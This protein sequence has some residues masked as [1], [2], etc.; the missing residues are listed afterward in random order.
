[1]RRI[2]GAAVGLL[3]L[4]VLSGGC[5]RR[6]NEIPATIEP[7]PKEHPQPVEDRGRD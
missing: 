1:M 5:D 4:V 6:R 3:I 2:L 7:L